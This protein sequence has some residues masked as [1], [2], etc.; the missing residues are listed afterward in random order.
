M[1]GK[2]FA[3]IINTILNVR[4]GATTLQDLT[5]EWS[6]VFDVA[7]SPQSGTYTFADADEETLYEE[8]D[9]QPF[10]FAGGYIDWTGA[11]AGAG[12]DTTVKVY[13]KLKSGGTYRKI[14]EETF[15]AAGVPDPVATP[16]PRNA[17]TD[18]TPGRI[19]NVY[20][21]KVTAKQAAEGGGWNS[22]DHEWYD[23]K[24]GN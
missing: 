6:S 8:S 5:D 22:I 9:D 17:T 24:R 10:V 18:C 15:L 1:I 2:W 13:L 16:H 14:Y 19:Y 20:G 12:E 21:V 23:G 3:D 4:G 11:N 7:R